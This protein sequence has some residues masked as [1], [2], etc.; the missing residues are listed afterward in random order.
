MRYILT[1]KGLQAY[2][3]SERLTSAILALFHVAFGVLILARPSATASA[4]RVFVN[5]IR[6]RL[7]MSESITWV[8][9]VFVVV[10]VLYLFINNRY[11]KHAMLFPFTCITISVL[12]VS[13][14]TVSISLT[15]AFL[16]LSWV[17]VLLA[18]V[19]TPE[20]VK[21]LMT[22]ATEP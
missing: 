2:R 19:W 9:V 14:A 20:I 12:I 15:L 16:Y 8:A 21:E 6:D 7:P 10:G 5:M 4:A 18:L 17:I 3:F 22:Y 1:G 11:L 13:V